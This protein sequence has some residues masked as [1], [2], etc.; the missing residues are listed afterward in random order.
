MKENSTEG[1][2]VGNTIPPTA[3]AENQATK[4]FPQ[5]ALLTETSHLRLI[6]ADQQVKISACAGGPRASLAYAGKTFTGYLDGDFTAWKLD[7]KQPA[8]EE[9]SVSVYETHKA[10]GTLKQIF[11]SFNKDLKTLCFQSQE[12]VETFAKENRQ[13]LRTDG[14]GTLFLFTEK[15]DNN[16][17]EFFVAYV[18]LGGGELR[19]YVYRLS[20]DFVWG[21]SHRRRI[22]VPATEPVQA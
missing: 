8:T 5:L 6:S 20:N 12:Q 18:R 14:Y 16:K 11:S 4:P 13:W 1:N 2:G 19:V 21:A 10:D 17:E 15:V 7:T 3:V 22:V 9:T